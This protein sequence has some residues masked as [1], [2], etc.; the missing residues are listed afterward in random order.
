M[1]AFVQQQ[2]MR[3][4]LD[5]APAAAPHALIRRVHLD[6]L[7][8]PPTPQE[9]LDFLADSHPLAYERM[10]ERAL[11]SPR[12][13]ER[14]AQ[15][16]LDLVRFAESS[17]YEMNFWFPNAWPYRDYVIRALNSDTTGSVVSATSSSAWAAK[18]AGTAF[19][20]RAA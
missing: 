16:W 1:D 8:I 20:C 9:I 3:A 19:C 11:A 2:R 13:G 10:V 4:E 6:L 17:G 5:P 12:Y 18:L 14:W 15:H 7:G